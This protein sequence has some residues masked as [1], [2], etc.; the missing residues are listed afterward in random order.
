MSRAARATLDLGA[1][2][3]NFEH[4]RKQAPA[5]RV[6]AVI[7]AN[8]YGHGLLRVARALPGAD[9]FGVAHIEE[10]LALRE[11]GIGQPIVLL[12][13]FTCA[14][15]I[16]L[17]ARQRIDTVVHHPEQ[18]RMLECQPP[19]QP[20]G[21]WLKLDTGMHRLGLAA[22]DA[23]AARMRLQ[24]CPGVELRAV[25]SHLARAD[26]P[27]Q[28]CSEQ[29]RAEFLRLSEGWG[30]PRSLA[31]SAALFAARR[32]HFD[33]VRP[34]LALYGMSPF[35]QGH[36]AELGLR[37][38]LSLRGHVVAVKALRRGEAVGYGGAW[39]ASR[40]TRL[41]IV[42]VGYAD[43]YPRHA[44]SG[45]P[46]LLGGRPCPLAGRVSMDMLAV[47]LPPEITPRLGEEAVLWGE[48]LPVEDIAR[49]AGTIPYE[50]VCK[51]TPRVRLEVIDG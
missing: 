13:G 15:E 19:P 32:Y 27:E 43:G 3:H 25:L 38:V 20:L 2:R 44:A 14:E 41:A 46:V 45:T 9:G 4:I 37:P 36:A 40:D 31:N 5:S 21:V 12:Q 42:A 35:A 50:L 6:L 17:L 18:V 23:D 26:E 39:R 11:G 30:L 33:W 10:A 48:G 28:P 29:Q 49:A 34:G 24:A 51:L 8:G 16:T 7:K 22:A 47:E 1:L